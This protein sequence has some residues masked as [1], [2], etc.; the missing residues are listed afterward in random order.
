V[1]AAAGAGL[2][3]RA[4]S[5]LIGLVRA[6]QTAHGF[7]NDESGLQRRASTPLAIPNTAC[8]FAADASNTKLVGARDELQGQK[9]VFKQ[10]HGLLGTIKR[11]ATMQ[12]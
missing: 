10:S 6:Q 8:P 3:C 4:R 9:Q 7:K 5:D 11:Q 1:G 12:W 2:G